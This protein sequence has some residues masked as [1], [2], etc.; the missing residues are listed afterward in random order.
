MGL[1]NLVRSK[2]Y[3][4]FMSKL[5]GV[6]AAIVIMGA[7]FKINHYPGADIMLII[8]LSTE[9]MIFFF[10]A[11]EPP[12]V[13]PDWSLVY[14]E[15]SGMY[16]GGAEADKKGKSHGSATEQ[17]DQMLAEAQIEPELLQRL[18]SGLR[19]LSDSAAKMGD[20][21]NAALVTNEYANSVKNATSSATELASSHKRAAEALEQDVHA[22]EAYLKSMRT[23]AEGAG[24]LGSAYAQ[25]A[26]LLKSDMR[27]T[28]E[29]SGSVKAAT[30][31]AQ[32]L[33]N[34][35]ANS[36]QKLNQSVEALDFSAVDGD[37]YNLQLRKISENL[38]A[39]NAVYEIQLTGSQKAV[40]SAEQMQKTMAEYLEKLNQST[41]N[42][43]QFSEQLSSLS[44]RISALNKVYGNML[45]AMNVNA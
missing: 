25:A 21:S 20:I 31:S 2:G 27:T 19:K 6:G 38:A 14:P 28:E 33:A 34:S 4:N 43:A 15:L 41:E 39:L 24:K 37:S 10:S 16:N 29:F 13:E 42:T 40:E 22:S 8:G 35:Y 12:H 30:E 9:A 44:N 18:G 5:Y 17:L 3:K 32:S 11:F 26:D 45:T 23:A 36:A 1:N 7:L